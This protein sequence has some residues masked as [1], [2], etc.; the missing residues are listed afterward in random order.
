MSWEEKRPFAGKVEPE[1][2]RYH[3]EEYPQVAVS[4]CG[5]DGAGEYRV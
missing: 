5:V 2:T 1:E 3:P 4:A